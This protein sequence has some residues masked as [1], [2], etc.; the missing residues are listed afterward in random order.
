M[1]LSYPTPLDQP[2]VCQG[3]ALKKRRKR[4]QG[5]ARRYFVLD[6]SGVLSYSLDP[7][8]P[9]RDQISIP[10]AAL[11]TAI[12]RKDIHIDASN[13]TF[14]IKCLSTDDFN[15]WM[16][17][18]RKFIVVDGRKSTL[19]KPTPRLSHSQWNRVAIISEAIGS[20]IAELEGVIAV[21]QTDHSHSK[22]GSLK[23]RSDKDKHGIH[24]DGS[25]FSKFKKSGTHQEDGPTPRPDHQS[26]CQVHFHRINVTL[27]SLK[28]HHVA[29]LRSLHAVQT[30]P[31]PSTTRASPPSAP[32]EENTPEPLSPSRFSTP[33]TRRSRKTPSLASL[34]DGGPIEWFDAEDHVGQEFVLDDPTPDE[35]KARP[36]LPSLN[37]SIHEYESESTGEEI[38][39]S[40]LVSEKL[41]PSLQ[42][43]QIVRRTRLPSG[44]VDDEGS[45]FA[46]LKKNIGK[47][48]TTVSFPV[49]FNEPLT[50][51]QRTAEEL[52]YYTL[53]Q[54][55]A[56][57]SDPV[58]RM[59]FVA[60]FAVSGYAH[61]RYRS[62]RKGFNPMLA[63]TFEDVRMK[64]IAEK[65]SHNPVVIAYHAEGDGWELGATSAGKTKFWGASSGKS[66][67]IIP[68]GTAFLQIGDD[69][70]EN[71][72]SSFM[73]NL[74]M[75]AKYLEHCGK[76]TIS[77]TTSGTSCILDFKQT[78]YWGA[79]NEVVGTV[80]SPSGEER[81]RIEGKWD[82]Q[83]ALVLDTSHFRVLW[84]VTPFPPQ[85]I[86]QYG[87]TAF[88]ITLNEM[89]SDLEGKLPATDSRYRPDVRALEE[90]DVDEA[91]RQKTRLE[92][93]QR[94]R[95]RR[96][97]DR[98]PRWFKQVGERWL[99]VGGYWEARAKGW[100][101]SSIEPLW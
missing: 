74:M 37:S 58:E 35:E 21:F 95:R 75:G 4:M 94:D 52:E 7:K 12:G 40:R 69:R 46:M 78:G 79:S 91:E 63:E 59:C 39:P 81:A 36:I 72:P 31:A 77:N 93:L 13:A 43:R 16:S 68:L 82:E 97:I 67:E 6:H 18:F 62:G 19:A 76:M 51:L 73:R 11:S 101:D 83:V 34:S 64:F 54:Q 57:A 10:H 26:M 2:V 98:S 50:M 65:V 44:P 8:H 38:V 88:G 89:T 84:R 20:T 3:W 30:D 80:L 15:T 96:G 27:E 87:F 86:E 90:G 70:F 5:F 48:L 60:A 53:L 33:F 99:Y 47:D 9:V 42:A 85:S 66:L 56:E 14:H 24:K 22:T 41:D 92:E 49:T 23:A 1:S 29:L 100:K 45:L 55:A 28:A 71:K 17:A 32:V 25:M 61:T